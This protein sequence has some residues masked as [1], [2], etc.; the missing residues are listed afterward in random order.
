MKEPFATAGLALEA[1]GAAILQRASV[2]TVGQHLVDAAAALDAL[3]A[4]VPAL[5]EKD[6]DNANLAGQRLAFCAERMK[7]AG[8]E[9]QG[10]VPAK[11]KGKSW[12]KG[13]L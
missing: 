3:A 13:G 2:P 11:P 7:V 8:Q 5:V 9:L 12:L 1:A 6:D 4:L 10:V